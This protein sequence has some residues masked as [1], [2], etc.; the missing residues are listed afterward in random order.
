MS[1]SATQGGH[2]SDRLVTIDMDQKGGCRLLCPFRGGAGSPS[3]TMWHG[4]R[5]TFVPTGILIHPAVWP[6]QTGAENWGLCPFGDLGPHLT[7]CRLALATSVTSGILIHPAIC[8]QQT[9]AENWG[10]SCAPLGELGLIFN[11]QKVTPIMPPPL[12]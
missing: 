3:D 11:L 4:P 1:A 6:Q 10:G 8:P 12:K 5:P 7:H 9:W 2:M